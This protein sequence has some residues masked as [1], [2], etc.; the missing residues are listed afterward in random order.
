MKEKLKKYN[1]KRNFDL[2]SEPRGKA[3]VSGKKKI[4]V[5]QFHRARREHFDFRLEW[6]GVLL[7]WAVPKGLSYNPKDKRLAVHVEDHPIDYA[8]FEGVIPKG[9]YGAGSVLL[10]DKGWWEEVE[11]FDDGFKKGS[12]KFVLHG[13][14][15]KGAWALVKLKNKD[16]KED[17]WII[18]KEKDE[19]AN[20][21]DGSALTSVKSGR[22]SEEIVDDG[23]KQNPFNEAKVQLATFVTKPPSS[24]N[25]L[26]EIKFDGFR[27]LA[28]LEDGKAR[29][30]SRNNKDFTSKFKEIADALE[31]FSKGRAMVLD[32]EIVVFDE[33]GRSDFGALQSYLKSPNGKSL[34][35]IVFD[36]LALDG[37]DL[38][39]RPLIE[40]KKK[41]QEALKY[42][43]ENIV[44]SDFVEGKGDE[45]FDVAQK[46]GL[47]G[48]IGKNKK[49]A[50]HGERNEDWVKCKCYKR[51]EFVVGG[52]T[53]KDKNVDGLSSLLLGAYDENGKLQFCGR[54]GSGLKGSDVKQLLNLFD[55]TKHNPFEKKLGAQAGEKLFFVEPKVVVEV[56]FTEW[57]HEQVLRQA[58]YKGIRQDKEANEVRF[59]LP[60]NKE[61][62]QET[63]V[64]EKSKKTVIEGVT[65][66]SP[67]KIIF[68]DDNISKLDI[69]KYYQ[70][71]AER[72]LPYVKER[73]LSVV[74]CHGDVSG[75]KF[76]K[77]HPNTTCEGV[78]VVSIANDEGEK[79]DYFYVKN[80]VGLLNE[81]QLGT[82]EF[83]PW[84]SHVK[85]LEK[86]DYMVFDLDPDEKMDLKQ[87]RQGVKDLKKV[88]D[89]LALKSFLKTSGGKGYH[90]VVPFVPHANW[91]S[92]HD[93]SENVSKL[94]ASKWPERYTTN[95][96]K[97][98]RKGKIFIDYMRNG[99]GSTSVAPYSLRAR[100]GAT[101]S[102]PISWAELDKIAPNEI[103]IKSAMMRLKKSD[104]WK[105]FFDVKQELRD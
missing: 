53:C 39:Q 68:K 20:L 21:D 92:F 59:E 45:C 14:R 84:G 73:I 66:S 89:E 8:E 31:D 1:D 44:V 41:L 19:F 47:E 54:T 78:E 36:I 46:L 32:G 9:Q 63:E 50:Y 30:V 82:I 74:R 64:E 101:V 76:F 55:V 48:I 62:E 81:V 12:I 96:R 85:T 95:V 99:R 83:H 103:N 17:N 58:S 10:W 79:S 22:T 90:V 38:R 35:Y 37:V 5:V 23:N 26:F 40:R 57:T 51:Q 52:F 69:V 16:A 2:T 15:L 61:I 43:P 104:P 97:D 34:V 105:N 49:S 33:R 93:F 98:A 88:L 24:K 70:A 75:E 6:R 11:S 87:I 18:I 60:L 56:Q 86:P 72:M 100:N 67:E 65:I 91:N 42:T 25:W 80:T 13:K 29:L 28:F 77:K 3:K 94:M 71:V 7:S 4:F 27:T 102:M